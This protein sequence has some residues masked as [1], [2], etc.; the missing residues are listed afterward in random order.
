MFSFIRLNENK[1]TSAFFLII[2]KGLFFLS[3]FDELIDVVANIIF[4]SYIISFWISYVGD[5]RQ[6]KIM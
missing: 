4:T 5:P 2:T 3:T 6:P 1:E